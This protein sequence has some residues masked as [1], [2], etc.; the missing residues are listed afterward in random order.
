M[1]AQMLAMERLNVIRCGLS[2]AATLIRAFGQPV[3]QIANHLF[4]VPHID[5]AANDQSADP[6]GIDSP[7]QI[8]PRGN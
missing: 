2:T 6:I 7:R 8:M 5:Y 3:S 1:A 4:G